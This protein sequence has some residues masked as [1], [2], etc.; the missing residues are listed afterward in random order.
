AE[1]GMPPGR[2]CEKLRHPPQ[3][4]LELHRREHGLLL[5]G[6]DAGVFLVIVD[7]SDIFGRLR[8]MRNIEM[9]GLPGASR[10]SYC[11]R[12]QPRNDVT[13]PSVPPPSPPPPLSPPP[14][15]PSPPPPPPS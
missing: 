5:A 4:D 9:P 3:D 8:R 15:P 7:R 14:S 10:A 6:L 11:C 2:V 13:P 1:G 12:A